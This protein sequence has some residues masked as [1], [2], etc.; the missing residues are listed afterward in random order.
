MHISVSILRFGNTPAFF[1]QGGSHL[2]SDVKFLQNIGMKSYFYQIHIDTSKRKS[3]IVLVCL[4]KVNFLFIKTANSVL[5]NFLFNYAKQIFC[6]ACK[7][8]SAQKI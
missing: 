3:I 7:K 8:H 5:L 2:P 1:P 6:A 4:V